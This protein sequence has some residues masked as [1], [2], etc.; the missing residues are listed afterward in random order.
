M[1][2]MFLYR[3]GQ[4]RGGGSGGASS[5]NDLADRPFGSEIGKIYS[6][7][8]EECIIEDEYGS[9]ITADN[10][11]ESGVEY[12]VIFNGEEY[13]CIAR[14]NDY[15][16]FVG[17]GELHYS[18]GGNGEPFFIE[19]DGSSDFSIYA[20]NNGTYTVSIYR[21]GEI[22]KKL[23]QKYIDNSFTVKFNDNDGKYT[24]DASF[25][26]ILSAHKAGRHVLCRAYFWGEY[27]LLPVVVANDD[28]VMFMGLTFKDGALCVYKIDVASSGEITDGI[29]NVSTTE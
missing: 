25:E 2:D 6:V 10:P 5:W 27:Y 8:D 23:D 20:T 24:V 14:S 3:F 1:N 15:A 26:E 28:H 7:K 12:T 19:D 16:T 9:Y 17:N 29:T 18:D 13:K 21:I 4:K 22:V 11:L